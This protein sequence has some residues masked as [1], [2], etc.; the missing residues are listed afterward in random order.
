LE[1]SNLGFLIG[2]ACLDYLIGGGTPFSSECLRYLIRGV[3][4]SL[5]ECRS[6]A[7]ANLMEGVVTGR[8]KSKVDLN[9]NKRGSLL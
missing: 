9:L 1:E 5:S 8:K 2:G 7:F 3:V 6:H 4:P